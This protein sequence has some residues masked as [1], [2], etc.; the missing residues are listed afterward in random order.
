MAFDEIKYR[1]LVGIFN[2]AGQAI[3]RQFSKPDR[4]E[5]KQI[6]KD[7]YEAAKTIIRENEKTQK[8]TEITQIQPA[9]EQPTQEQPTSIL[10]IEPTTDMTTE[11]I[12]GGT[13]CLPCSRDHLSVSAG[14]LKEA[15]RFANRD[16]GMMDE[17]VKWRIHDALL[18][19]NSMERGDLAPRNIEELQGRERELAKWALNKSAELRH[20][21]TKAQT[22]DDLITVSKNAEEISKTFM[23]EIWDLAIS[24]GTVQKL[25]QGKE[26]AEYQTCI[27][28]ISEVLSEKGRVDYDNK[29]K[30]QRG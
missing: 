15:V 10:G 29:S 5:Y 12:E 25:C 24:D 16:K 18:E 13:A 1:V 17:E 3:S 21:I 14:F 26:G 6:N 2:I 19:L 11:K 9:Q 22:V 23:T 4:E 7:Y 20:E 28:T 30:A 8:P 27:E